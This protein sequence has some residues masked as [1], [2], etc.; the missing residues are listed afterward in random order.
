MR[1]LPTDYRE[2]PEPFWKRFAALAALA[3]AAWIAV[4][5]SLY[6][7]FCEPDSFERN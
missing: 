5:W 1:T 2:P 4:P 6:E 3:V 7:L